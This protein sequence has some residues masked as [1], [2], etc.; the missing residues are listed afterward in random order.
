[1]NTTNKGDIFEEHVF[2]TLKE[3]LEKDELPVN[4]KYCKIYKKKGY[5]SSK[6]KSDI[7]FDIS[8]ECTL[9]GETSP[10]IYLVVEC[11]DYSHAVPV[12]DLEEFH[13]KVLQV[14]GL[15]VKALFFTTNVLQIGALNYAVSS[16]IR[17]MRIRQEGKREVLSFRKE[18]NAVN[19]NSSDFVNATLALT[20]S[21][22]S[23]ISGP[24]VGMGPGKIYHNFLEILRDAMTNG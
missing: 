6:R 8:I 14:T 7:I 4:G 16:G 17:V 20:S 5:F 13:S 9:P 3:M 21:V 22:K 18:Q 23:M 1:M 10:T 15:N 24:Y 19:K 12:N 2:H 11:K